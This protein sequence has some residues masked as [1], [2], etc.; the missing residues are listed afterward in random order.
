MYEVLELKFKLKHEVLAAC[1]GL[2]TFFA[3]FEAL[4]TIEKPVFSIFALFSF[5]FVAVLLFFYIYFVLLCIT[6]PFRKAMEKSSKPSQGKKIKKLLKQSTV[7]YDLSEEVELPP[8][9]LTQENRDSP[10]PEK[11]LSD[12]KTD[13]VYTLKY[14][15]VLWESKESLLKASLTPEDFFEAYDDLTDYAKEILEADSIW[16]SFKDSSV[17][18]KENRENIADV[19]NGNCFED[20]LTAFIEQSYDFAKAKIESKETASDKRNAARAWH[21]SFDPYLSRIPEKEIQLLHEK[22]GELIMLADTQ[23]LC[24]L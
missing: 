18:S 2:L 24:S 8:D 12:K 10:Q 21:T 23:N 19:A 7:D 5:F 13:T 4:L 17:I 20:E 6:F 22:Y 14:A 9:D 15:P 16:L 3:I 1:S 11:V